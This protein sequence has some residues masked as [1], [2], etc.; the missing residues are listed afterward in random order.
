MWKRQEKWLVMVSF[1]VAVI[2][3]LSM[4]GRLFS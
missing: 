3:L 4:V 2:M 1:F